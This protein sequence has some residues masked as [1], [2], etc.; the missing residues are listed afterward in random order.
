M[1]KEEKDKLVEEVLN[2]FDFAKVDRVM[3]MLNWEWAIFGKHRAIPGIYGLMTEAKDMLYK[4]LNDR[5]GEDCWMLC[6]GFRASWDGE[7][8]G[9]EFILTSYETNTNYHELTENDKNDL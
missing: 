8:L 7:N 1:T 3:R 5:D 2:E 4:V 6:G 9:L